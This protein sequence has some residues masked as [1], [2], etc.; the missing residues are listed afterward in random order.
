[1]SLDDLR[2]ILLETTGELFAAYG[3]MAE[4]AGE[5]AIDDHTVCG[6]LGFTGDAIC[7]AI[8]IAASREAVAACTPVEGGP[9]TQWLAELTNQVVGRFKN[10]LVR[11]GADIWMS[12]PV[13]LSATRLTPAPW[14]GVVPIHLRVG[15]APF[16]LWLEVEGSIALVVPVDEG[17]LR[18]GEA[19]LF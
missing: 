7:G 4:V 19:L 16:T 2:E 12:L 15:G 1:M 10:A 11:R 5:A 8:V 17:M 3:V 6:I 18:E 13:V 9:V 14:G